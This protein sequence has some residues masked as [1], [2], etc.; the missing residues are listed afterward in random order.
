[1]KQCINN[2]CKAELEDYQERCPQCGWLQKKIEITELQQKK[3]T[4]DVVIKERHGFITFWLWLLIVSNILFA[5][6]AFFPKTMWGRNYPDEYVMVSVFS[7]VLTLINVIGEFLLL[8][9][10]RVGF[11]IIAIS[12]TI[13]AMTLFTKMESIPVGLIG[14]VVLWFVLKIKKHGISYWDA[15]KG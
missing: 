13:V 7:G 12:S 6:V 8:A 1:M 2:T 11:T 4:D 3:E 14:V 5:I 9:W 10:K 15:M